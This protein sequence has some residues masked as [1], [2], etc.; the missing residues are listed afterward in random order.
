[1]FTNF[2]LIKE[3]FTYLFI[4]LEGPNYTF[5]I[6]FVNTI[7]FIIETQKNQGGSDYSNCPDN[8][9][10]VDYIA[11]AVFKLSEWITLDVSI[12]KARVGTDARRLRTTQITGQQ[13]NLNE[14]KIIFGRAMIREDMLKVSNTKIGILALI[15]YTR[16][17]TSNILFGCF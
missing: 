1:M 3:V 8:W 9:N 15:S 7:V 13:R 14:T 2:Q 6:I 17:L 5:N 4:R 10:C 11:K 12:S 16:K